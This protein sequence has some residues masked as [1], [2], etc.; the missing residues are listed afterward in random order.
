MTKNKSSLG[1]FELTG[2]PPAP[3]GVTQVE[4]TFHI[5]ANGILNLTAAENS[6]GKENKVTVTSDNRPQSNEEIHR[7]V[8][9]AE[10][11]RAEDEMQK[12]TNSAQNDLKSYCLNMKRSVKMIN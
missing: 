10:K 8:N 9:K 6:T 3:R 1:N 4:V 2:I 5:A 11:Y 12:Q 7:M